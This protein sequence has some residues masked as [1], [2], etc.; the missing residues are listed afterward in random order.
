MATAVIHRLEGGQ[1][2]NGAYS[3]VQTV[4]EGPL[5]GLYQVQERS[6]GNLRCLRILPASIVDKPEKRERFN[7]A[8]QTAAQVSAPSH[9]PLLSFGISE[10]SMVP[11]LL[12]PWLSGEDLGALLRRRAFLT[13]AETCHISRQLGE[14]L[15]ALHES[16]RVHGYL[17]PENLHLLPAPSGESGSILKVVDLG[18]GQL[19]LNSDTRT[20]LNPMH[21]L[22]WQAPEQTTTGYTISPPTDIWTMGLLVFYMIT[23]RSYFLAAQRSPLSVVDLLREIAL[24]PFEPATVRAGTFGADAR[25]PPGFDRWFASCV[26]R[27]REQR[28]ASVREAL[29]ALLRLFPNSQP[30]APPPPAPVGTLGISPRGL[31]ELPQGFLFAA[32]YRVVRKLSEGGMGILYE[33]EQLSTSHRRALKL[34]QPQLFGNRQMQQRF[35]REARVTAQIPSDHVVQVLDAG[36]DA[37]TSMPWLAMEL[38]DGEDLATLVSRRG[39]LPHE[40]VS[41]ILAQMSHA[42]DAAHQIGIVHRDLKP[43]NIY[44]TRPRRAG[45]L[46]WVKLLDFGIAKVVSDSLTTALSTR[47]NNLGTPLWM[48]P[49]QTRLGDP[50]TPATDIWALGLLAFFLLT[51]RIYWR[52][53]ADERQHAVTG[54]LREVIEE[55]LV[56]AS[57]RAREYG[58]S[59]HIPKGFDA[60]FVR[61]VS[62][63]PASRYVSAQ[64]AA[65]ALAAILESQSPELVDGDEW[66][67]PALAPGQILGGQIRLVAS[68][69]QRTFGS[70]YRGQNVQTGQPLLV[71]LYPPALTLSPRR[72]Q[73]F[74]QTLHALAT[75][76][77]EA[78]L[79]ILSFGVDPKTR[80]PWVA[81]PF[82]DGETLAQR[83]ARGPLSPPDLGALLNALGSCLGTAHRATAMHVHGVINP[84]SIWLEPISAVQRPAVVC[85]LDFGVARLLADLVSGGRTGLPQTLP[86]QR[87]APLWLWISPEDV[88]R[89]SVHA[90]S[91]TWALGLL[92][93]QLLAGRSYWRQSGQGP[94]MLFLREVVAEPLEPASTRARELGLALHLPPRAAASFDDWFARCMS[95]NPQLR[96]ASDAATQ[97]LMRILGLTEP[98]RQA[99]AP[100]QTDLMPA[101]RQNL[102]SMYWAIAL[103][104]LFLGLLFVM[105]ALAQ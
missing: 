90:G 33:V 56:P 21:M 11:W 92:G 96:P 100:R 89:G 10:G 3:H 85:L 58:V 48:A 94:L 68:L 42:L 38:L 40:E 98:T 97:E 104:A 78:A 57:Q 14:Y 67:L 1:L 65:N 84:D 5:G 73:A 8:M 54:V 7:R 4:K 82:S 17:K 88:E 86:V 62:R 50:I 60:W 74:E 36:I 24:S 44:L 32:G 99:L 43:E 28:F 9:V 105:A 76:P 79:P 13:A 23:G 12:T 31:V 30:A 22:P 64:E 80:I 49:E 46:L 29:A 103:G 15:I 6:T 52:S 26:C 20:S 25:L 102:G 59:E 2:F 63:E 69:Q 70:I 61:C 45:V 41:L 47:V 93:F 53:G 87:V 101:P 83:L 18:L 34:M 91:D 72:M 27:E 37:P 16:G 66:D 95:R 75:L 39:A 51:G 71:L 35:L 77:T 55:P 81:H 19:L